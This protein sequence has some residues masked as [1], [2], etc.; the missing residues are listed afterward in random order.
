MSLSVVLCCLWA[1]AATITALLPYKR[2]FPPGIFLLVA[3]PFLIVFLGYQHG[4]IWA[5]L[6]LAGFASMFRN[7]L[8]YLVHKAM[9][10]LSK[11][12]KDGE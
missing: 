12:P 9:G 4:M 10:K 1:V 2:Q 8:I 5:V 6:A 11:D 3:A 7:P